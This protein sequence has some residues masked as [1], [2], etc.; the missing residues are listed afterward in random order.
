[1]QKVELDGILEIYQQFIHI[2]NV[3]YNPF[4][5]DGDSSA[6]ATVNKSSLYGPVTFMQKEECVNYV[7]KW[8]NSNLRRL[9]MECKGKNLEDG[10][11]MVEREG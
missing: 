9:K 8:M 11:G 5:G 7:T 2:H 1:M 10:K 3:L 4:I 6:Y